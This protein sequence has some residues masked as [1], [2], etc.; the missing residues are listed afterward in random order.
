MT[1]AKTYI[2]GALPIDHLHTKY[3]RAQWQTV[4]PTKRTFHTKKRQNQNAGYFEVFFGAQE[5][6]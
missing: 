4:I 5:S 1:K 6:W 3:N 2:H